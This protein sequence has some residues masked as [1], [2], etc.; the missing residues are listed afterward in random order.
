MTIF[1]KR[2]SEPFLKDLF[3]QQLTNDNDRRSN[4]ETD[5]KSIQ[6]TLL[7]TPDSSLAEN[8]LALLYATMQGCHQPVMDIFNC[9]TSC[10]RF[11][12]CLGISFA[13]REPLGASGQGW[14]AFLIGEFLWFRP[15]LPTAS[16]EFLVGK[17]FLPS[18]S[19]GAPKVF[20][21]AKKSYA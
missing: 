18:S 4:D 1:W 2:T 10:F 13:F 9:K 6:D 20:P 19:P 21:K 17:G 14:G 16:Q 11:H 12:G 7:T 8:Q 15:G 3:F 5:R